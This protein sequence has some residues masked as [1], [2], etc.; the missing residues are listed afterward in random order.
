MSNKIFLTKIILFVGFSIGLLVLISACNRSQLSTENP[1]LLQKADSIN[2]QVTGEGIYGIELSKL[3][4]GG[5]SHDNLQ[6]YFKDQ[7]W[8][9][10][11]TAN[12][13]DAIIMFY[14]ESSSSIYSK[15][16]VY[17]LKLGEGTGEIITEVDAGIESDIQADEYYIQTLRIEENE[18]YSPIASGEDNWFW[19]RL[20]APTTFSTEFSLE[21]L[22]SGE[23]NILID[24]WGLTNAPQD[25]DHR[26]S[27][28][29]NGV[30]IADDT[31]DGQIEHSINIIVPP[32]VLH[33]GLNELELVFPGNDGSFIDIQ[34]LNKIEIKYPRLSKLSDDQHTFSAV[35]DVIKFHQVTNQISVFDITDPYKTTINGISKGSSLFHSQP[36]HSYITLQPKG[37]LTPDNITPA[38]L[39]PDLKN[40][41]NAADY[42]IIGPEELLPP[43][44]LL[45]DLRQSEGLSVMRIPVSAVYDQFN[46]GMPE[47]EALNAF[48]THA[49]SNWVIQPEYVLLVG[50][51]SYD[52]RGYAH[53]IE[54]FS[55][56][57][58]V[59]DTQ[60]GGQTVSDVLL[61]DVNE[62][63]WPD[64]AIGRLPVKNADQV[65]V[66]VKKIIQYEADHTQS[67]AQSRILAIADNQ[68]ARFKQDANSFLQ[69]FPSEF[70][71][72]LVAP[73]II[74]TPKVN[75][76]VQEI[77]KENLITAYFG[78]GSVSMWGK[79]S[80]FTNDDVSTLS[81]ADFLPIMI[82]STCLTGLFIHPTQNSLTEELLLDPENGAVAVIAPTSLTL[83]TDQG[84]F[85]TEF[86]KSLLQ[87]SNLRLGDAVLSAWRSMP[88]I[89]MN[90]VEVMQTF[91]LFGDPTLGLMRFN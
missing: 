19:S 7:P 23:G 59:I 77:N 63:P 88:T 30:V 73:D 51:S 38:N 48:L 41:E 87:T 66:Y 70:Q 78:H 68:E 42:L 39:T 76:I 31:W 45:I 36:G 65:E 89:N 12:G 57:S 91:L 13:D 17:Q 20:V 47:P 11:I 27:V 58:K 29:I 26:T 56:P 10:R 71:T 24:L 80:L 5:V 33:S 37:W 61:A 28:M 72:A 4:W 50:D 54:L 75:D 86:V 53:P 18:F 49:S 15:Y 62:D 85:T 25:P 3:G 35:G 32:G 9:F 82:H 64:L 81:N 46:G 44:E 1:E 90:T 22:V 52:F 2:I 55:L 16:N 40:S 79:D 34:F 6:L 60:F 8:P 21:E 14:A 43:L 67:D 74:D 69:L 84:N 83:P